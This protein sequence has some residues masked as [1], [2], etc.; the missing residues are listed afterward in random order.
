MKKY[1][2]KNINKKNSIGKIHPR[3][4]KY[5]FMLATTPAECRGV[6]IFIL[7]PNPARPVRHHN[8]KVL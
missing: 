1:S 6:V 7:V 3:L 2:R 5:H 4:L 8:L